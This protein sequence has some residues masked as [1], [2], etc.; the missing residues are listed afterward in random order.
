MG[1][2]CLMGAEFLFGKMKIFCKWI[3]GDGT[4]ISCFMKPNGTL[5]FVPIEIFITIFESLK[6]NAH[7][8]L[9]FC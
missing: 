8:T 5:K 9:S 1:K 4:E 3:V 2:Y 6:I 7:D